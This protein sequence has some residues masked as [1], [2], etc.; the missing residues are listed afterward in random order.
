MRFIFLHKTFIFITFPRY[1][2]QKS[3]YLYAF[4]YK[5]SIIL[6]EMPLIGA[7]KRT[8]SKKQEAVQATSALR[9]LEDD[10][11]ENRQKNHLNNSLVDDSFWKDSFDKLLDDKK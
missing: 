3:E 1:F 6:Y 2:I 9:F 8:Y 4:I 7:I 11:K 10:G 5:R